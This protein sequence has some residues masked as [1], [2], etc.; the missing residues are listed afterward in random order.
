MAVT[1]M[2]LKEMTM[3]KN[4]KPHNCLLFVSRLSTKTVDDYFINTEVV[5]CLIC[6]ESMLVVIE[7][8]RIK[9]V[10][11][12]TYIDSLLD[13]ICLPVQP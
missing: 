10:L 4:N 11:V 6:K 7:R 3:R 2:K 1:R 12:D 13:S 9:H 8:E 5:I